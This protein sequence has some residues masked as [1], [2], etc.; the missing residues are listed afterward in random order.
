MAQA[1]WDQKVFSFLL[2]APSLPP[3]QSHGLEVEGR[4]LGA[5]WEQAIMKMIISTSQLHVVLLNS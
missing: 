1:K 2:Q 5:P 3:L 4:D